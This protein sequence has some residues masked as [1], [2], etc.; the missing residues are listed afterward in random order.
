ML[1]ICRN[2]LIQ[3]D[4]ESKYDIIYY[5][6]EVV[7]IT[8]FWKCTRYVSPL[9]FLHIFV[10][11]VNKL[12]TQEVYSGLYFTLIGVMADGWE[13]ELININGEEWR[14]RGNLKQMVYNIVFHQISLQCYSICTVGIDEILLRYF[15]W[16]SENKYGVR[17]LENWKNNN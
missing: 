12:R 8:E 11:D 14:C 10:L 5:N 4:K 1:G 17:W 9:S 3:N 7:G 13:H 15:W 6:V 2:N 16:K